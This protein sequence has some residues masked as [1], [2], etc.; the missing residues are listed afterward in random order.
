MAEIPDVMTDRILNKA[1]WLAAMVMIFTAGSIALLFS[2]S[3]IFELIGARWSSGIAEL[4]MAV[5]ATIGTLQLCRVRND[6]L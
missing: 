4:L 2:Y 6:L 1:W 5:V 3:G